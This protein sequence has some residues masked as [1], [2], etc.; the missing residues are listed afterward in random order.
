M[1]NNIYR[2]R[3]F[4]L[5]KK[6]TCLFIHNFFFRV[7]IQDLPLPD[8]LLHIFVQHDQPP[9]YIDLLDKIKLYSKV[10]KNIYVHF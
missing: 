5:L 1:T 10:K 9:K 3:Y 7:S 6:K 8:F 2:F 4:L